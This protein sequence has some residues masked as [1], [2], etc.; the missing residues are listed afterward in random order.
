MPDPGSS[1]GQALIRHPVFSM[2]SGFRRNDKFK[3]LVAGVIVADQ[4]RKERA[5]RK[6][7]I[8]ICGIRP[9]E[10]VGDYFLVAEKNLAFSQKGSPYLSVRLKDKTGEVDGKVWD[11]AVEWDKAFKRGDIVHIESRAVNFKNGVQLSITDV[12]KADEEEIDL[13][14]YIPS[15]KRD[16]EEMF[17]EL[18]IFV[19]SIKD[20][21]LRALLDSFLRDEEIVTGLKKAPAA[22]GLH[23]VYLGGLLEHTLSVTRL[24]DLVCGHYEGINRD[25]LLTGG[26]LHDIGKIYEFSYGRVF[27]YTDRGRLIGHIVMSVEMV[28]GRISSIDDFPDHLALKLRHLLL[29]HHGDLEYGSPKRP[30]TVE[31]LMVH[32]VDDLDAKVNAFQEFIDA[33][34]DDESD[35]TPF[36]RLFERFIYKG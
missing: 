9:G 12:K 22:K 8:Y 16:A 32:F 33:S 24:L 17:G 2:D 26:I 13:S 34:R 1:P 27:D 19:E 4:E 6:K 25:L 29:S 21:H 28:D 10:K 35:W 18:M 5:L 23:H 11:N 3:Y 15:A 31:A 36:H 7:N 30:K 14:D 20:P